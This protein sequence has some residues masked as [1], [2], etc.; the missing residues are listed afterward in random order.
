MQR[1]VVSSGSGAGGAGERVHSCAYGGAGSSGGGGG[2]G[3]ATTAINGTRGEA[4]FGSSLFGVLEDVQSW[5]SGCVR[6][7]LDS[8]ACDV[9]EQGK[10]VSTQT[11]SAATAAAAAAAAT[12]APASRVY[13]RRA[14]GSLH[15]FAAAE[16]AVV[17]AAALGH[18]RVPRRGDDAVFQCGASG[19]AV[20][21]ED[22]AA[23]EAHTGRCAERSGALA[24][25]TGAKC[26]AS[27]ANTTM[28]LRFLNEARTD[29]F[30]YVAEYSHDERGMFEWTITIFLAQMWVVFLAFIVSWRLITVGHL[31]HTTNPPTRSHPPVG[32]FP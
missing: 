12:S 9:D 18:C 10:C 2:G 32:I 14:T 1:P 16:S 27:L 29:E 7:Y 19:A 28:A 31:H 3:A 4:A 21:A 22:C 13:R 5:H 20:D 11:A 26:Q 17:A 24:A 23:L 8:Q 15:V 30:S 6:I 25:T